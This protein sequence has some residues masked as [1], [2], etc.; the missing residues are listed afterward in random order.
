M[1]NKNIVNINNDHLF[2]GL[3]IC[4]TFFINYTDL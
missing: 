1:Q 4:F 3:C 2:L